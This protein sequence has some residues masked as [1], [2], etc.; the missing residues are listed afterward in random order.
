MHQVYG[1]LQI[2]LL[3]PTLSSFN[4]FYMLSFHLDHSEAM[5]RDISPALAAPSPLLNLLEALSG[6]VEPPGQEAELRQ[7]LQ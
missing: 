7:E 4:L 6:H 1:E 3:L 5:R 2:L